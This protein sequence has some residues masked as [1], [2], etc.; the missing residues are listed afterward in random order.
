MMMLLITAV[1]AAEVKILSVRG[2]IQ[3]VTARYIVEQIQKTDSEYTQLIILELDTPGGLATSMKEITTAIMNSPVPVCVYVSPSGAHAA[4][5]GFFILMSSDVAAMAPSTTTGSAHPVNLMGGNEKD[6]VMLAKVTNDFAASIRSMAENHGRNVDLAEKAVR[7][8]S[9]FTE[10]EAHDNNLIEIIALNRDDLLTGLDGLDVTRPDGTKL[11]LQIRD[12]PVREHPMSF[13]SKFLSIIVHPEI[14]LVLMA[15]GMLGLWVEFTHPG[16][17]FPGVAGAACLLLGLYAM[18]VLP[19]NY[20]G[21]A[22]I[23]LG[24]IMFILEVKVVSYGMLTVGGIASFI[25]GALMLHDSPIPGFQISLG[26]IIVVAVTM[27]AIIVLFGNLVIRAHRRKPVTGEIGIVGETGRVVE[28]LTPGGKVFV[29]GEYWNASAE[30]DIPEGQEVEI[31]EVR[32]MN[33]IVRPKSPK[34][35]ETWQA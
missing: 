19:I 4:S 16:V 30:T 8:A 12:L 28:A 14:A 20:A 5:A 32:G 35:G 33:L 2:I 15:L 27:A 25:V 21:L 7:E 13:V 17:V 31:V 3:P 9:S 6:S 34:G 26:F 22:L 18:S 29:H 11:T 10:Q 24:I 23:F 1:L